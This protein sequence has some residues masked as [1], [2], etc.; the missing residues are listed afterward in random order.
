M[1]LD[2]DKTN[3]ESSPTIDFA[4]MVSTTAKSIRNLIREIQNN[5]Q[6]LEIVKVC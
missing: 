6:D 5:P 1:L 3:D 4:G 2:I